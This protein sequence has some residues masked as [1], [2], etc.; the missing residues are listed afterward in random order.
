[1]SDLS[2]YGVMVVH[3][4]FASTGFGSGVGFSV[5]DILK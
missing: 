4:R 1:V 3:S 2:F 5:I